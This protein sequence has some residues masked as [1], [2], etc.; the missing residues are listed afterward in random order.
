MKWKWKK[1]N[2]KSGKDKEVAAHV[3]YR[4]S[5]WWICLNICV[6]LPLGHYHSK[7]RKHP[8]PFES[9]IY[10]SS[11]F[12]HFSCSIL[13]HIFFSIVRLAPRFDS[14]IIMNFQFLNVYSLFRFGVHRSLSRYI[15]RNNYWLLNQQTIWLSIFSAFRFVYNIPLRITLLGCTWLDLNEYPYLSIAIS[16][17]LLLFVS[18]FFS[19]SGQRHELAKFSVK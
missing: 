2:S 19:A 10:W 7:E 6:L 18:L 13:A 3:L 14:I 1:K 11:F 12:S 9:S 17:L 8:N 5:N 4:L 15:Y 16:F